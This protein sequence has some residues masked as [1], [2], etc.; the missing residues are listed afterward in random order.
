MLILSKKA[1]RSH[2]VPGTNPGEF[3]MVM[4]SLCRSAFADSRGGNRTRPAK[5]GAQRVS[6]GS[7]SI[8]LAAMGII[9]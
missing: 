3:S 6:I 1:H 8:F 9:L 5:S 4:G 7:R 2:A